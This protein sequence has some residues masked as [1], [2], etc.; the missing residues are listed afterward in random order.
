MGDCYHNIPP[1][2]PRFQSH[3]FTVKFLNGEFTPCHITRD[4]GT[5]LFWI[6]KSPVHFPPNMR[7]ALMSLSL[8]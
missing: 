8:M 5:P 6:S 4:Q 7:L 3:A 2:Q 1:D